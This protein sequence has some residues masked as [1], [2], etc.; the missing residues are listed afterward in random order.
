VTRGWYAIFWVEVAI[1][2][3]T[4][5]SW[6]AAPEP[7]LRAV[8][9]IESPDL[10]DHMVLLL[11]ANTVLCAYVYLYAR[12]LA[13]RPFNRHA[14]RRLQEAMALGDVGILVA[15]AVSCAQLSPDPLWMAGQIG[16]ASVW[17]GIRVAW[18]V[19]TRSDREAA[20]SAT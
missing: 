15:S 11:G 13:D 6:I 19:R 8:M 16:M 7:F 2:A 10:R 4:A 18:L 9:G 1:C 17:L 20:T 12:L 5:L 3:A 14:F